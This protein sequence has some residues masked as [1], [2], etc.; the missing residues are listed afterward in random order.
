MLICSFGYDLNVAAVEECEIYEINRRI[1]AKVTTPTPIRL[2]ATRIK[3]AR[4][5]NAKVLEEIGGYLGGICPI[6]LLAADK[7]AYNS[8][9]HR[10]TACDNAAELGAVK[11]CFK[12]LTD[13]ETTGWKVPRLTGL[14]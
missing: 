6:E 13:E 12:L 11:S 10:L 1:P 7:P 5:Q 2:A 8:N 14:C 4:C 9:F 3:P